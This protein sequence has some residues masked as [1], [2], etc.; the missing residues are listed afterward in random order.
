MAVLF[1]LGIATSSEQKAQ[2]I[3]ADWVQL[4]Q[5]ADPL[6]QQHKPWG[7]AR[8]REDQAK[9]FVHLS[10]GDVDYYSSDPIKKAFEVIAYDFLRKDAVEFDYALFGYEAHDRLI[11]DAILKELL[12]DDAADYSD[13]D[14][15]FEWM[16]SGYV[17]Q[18]RFLSSLKN[19]DQFS[20]FKSNYGWIP[21]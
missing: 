17:F 6:L 21:Y 7:N 9:W 15:S 1:D 5:S 2:K 10:L 14:Y 11:G 12:E 16:Y 13:K 3:V 19:A 20:V 8:Y 4:S 18:E